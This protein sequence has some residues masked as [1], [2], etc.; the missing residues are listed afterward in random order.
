M[1]SVNACLERRKI[2]G[3]NKSNAGQKRLKILPVL[4]LTRD[5]QRAEGSSVERIV[6]RDDFELLGR[7]LE[8]WARTILRA[9]SIASVPVLAKNERASPLTS[10]SFL[11]SGPWYSW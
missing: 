10:A 4:G 2:V 7:I 5:G 8:P 3:L 6:Q 1:R 11:A 9:P